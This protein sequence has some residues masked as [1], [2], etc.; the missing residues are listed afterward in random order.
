M[1]FV[2]LIVGLILAYCARNM[3]I[4]K[5]RSYVGWF[6]A[7]FFIPPAILLLMTLDD[8]KEKIEYEQARKQKQKEQE[9]NLQRKCPYCAEYIKK[10]AKVCKHC[11]RD[12][13]EPSE[14]TEV[15]DTQTEI[16]IG[17]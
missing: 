3:A 7:T 1:L 12:I 2:W 16:E 8:S 4:K 9:Q 17:K 5:G 15:N 10:E 11:G 13:A 6:W 14:M